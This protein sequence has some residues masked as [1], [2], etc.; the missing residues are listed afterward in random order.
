MIGQRIW[1]W[2]WTLVLVGLLAMGLGYAF[3]P[4]PVAVDLGAVV[5]GPMMVGITDDGVTR[6]KELYVVSAPVTGYLTRIEL[7]AGDTVAK[8]TLITRM[9]GRPSA[10]IDARSR[11][12]I[13][14]ALAA[15]RAGAASADAT[16]AQARRDLARAEALAGRG[17]LPRAQLEAARTRVIAGVAAQARSRAEIAQ[18]QARLGPSGVA[19]SSEVDVRA[20]AGGSVLSV[21][22]ESAAVVA[23]GTPLMAI[24]DAARI[25]LVV[26]LLSRE[27]VRAKAGDPV[28]ITQWGGDAPLHG[29]VARIEPFGRLKVSALGIEEQRVNLI[30]QFDA[31]SVAQAAR[32]GHG[33]QVDATIILWRD[34]VVQ[35]PIGALFRGSE[36]DWQAFV[37][38]KGRARLRTVKVGHINDS[39]AE[40]LDGLK[41]GDAVILDPG[42]TVTEGAR[43][44]PR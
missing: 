32:L 39:V 24:G 33:Y 42:N 11:A 17:F 1:R 18:A 12:E 3:W 13:Q 4:R 15:A 7:E 36:G 25:E 43:V 30:V 23:E 34:D 16:L 8:G 41:P 5:R 38:E 9:S 27:A 35:V 19:S 20:P 37:P 22:T 29:H 31:D 21:I 26:D 14:A 10:P 28:E 44:K 40:V 2:R 6:A